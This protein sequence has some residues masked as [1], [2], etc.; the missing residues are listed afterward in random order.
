MKPTK[1]SAHYFVIV[2]WYAMSTMAYAPGFVYGRTEPSSPITMEG[3]PKYNQ[4]DPE[5]PVPPELQ[6]AIKYFD[7]WETRKRSVAIDKFQKF[8]DRHPHHIFVPEAYYI[9]GTLYGSKANRNLGESFVKSKLHEYFSKAAQAY[10]N[11]YARANVGI[12]STMA[13]MD[14]THAS[15][16]EWLV[17]MREQANTSQVYPIQR[18]R[19]VMGGYP[20]ILSQQERTRQ[21]ENF[22][23]QMANRIQVAMK[24]AYHAMESE[25]E[26]HEY[27]KEC[28]AV[29]E[30]YKP[31]PQSKHDVAAIQPKRNLAI[32]QTRQV[33][34]IPE[35]EAEPEGFPWLW[36]ATALA[37]LAITSVL[38]TYAVKSRTR[39]KQ[40]G[41]HAH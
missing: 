6:E 21:I 39:N 26:W 17:S 33:P 27:C 35:P 29:E 23:E 12:K 16:Y 3:I 24:N 10:G 22:K 31:S 11:Y 8:I 20:V 25:E 37:G 1:Q 32:T 30:L 15:Y 7:Q 4:Y 18:V 34:P 41:K 19:P 9:M 14:H 28:K 2:L 36:I 38:L 13:M 40:R 5:H